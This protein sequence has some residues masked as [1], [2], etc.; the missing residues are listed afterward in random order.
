MDCSVLHCYD[1]HNDV[2]W[3]IGLGRKSGSGDF[4]PFTSHHITMDP[5]GDH[6][7]PP[8]IE[9]H[10]RICGK[11]AT[12]GRV[13]SIACGARANKKNIFG[14]DFPQFHPARRFWFIS[15][16]PRHFTVGGDFLLLLFGW[17]CGPE[18]NLSRVFLENTAWFCT[19][20]VWAFW[21][22]VDRN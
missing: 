8:R 3:R 2:S 4:F 16:R 15:P 22:D 17:S 9:T 5:Q 14:C 21:V 6:I 13:P 12:R 11:K 19:I 18:R 1:R 10:L 7:P 20:M